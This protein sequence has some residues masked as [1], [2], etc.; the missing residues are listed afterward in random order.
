MPR[1]SNNSNMEIPPGAVSAANPEAGAI[2]QLSPEEELKVNQYAQQRGITQGEAVRQLLDY[3][4]R[5]VEQENA[6]TV[7]DKTLGVVQQAKEMGVVSSDPNDVVNSMARG[8]VV[9]SLAK[10]LEGDDGKKGGVSMSDLKEMYYLRIMGGHGGHKRQ[11]RRGNT[12]CNKETGGA[13]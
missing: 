12:R 2:L 9:K 11:Q 6:P 10:G 4:D 7:I 5:W 1:Q 3:S 13:E 8:V